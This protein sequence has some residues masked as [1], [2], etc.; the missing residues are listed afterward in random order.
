MT[1][2]TIEIIDK[3]TLKLIEDLES[4]KLIRVL[5]GKEKTNKKKLSE[6]LAGSLS[7]LQAKAWNKELEKMR[8]EWQ[9]D[10]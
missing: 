10:I 6:R 4:M 7:P 5:K 9:R 3:K 2:L 1:Q 8:G